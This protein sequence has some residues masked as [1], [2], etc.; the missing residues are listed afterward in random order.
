M[1]RFERVLIIQ[2]SIP[3]DV[4]SSEMHGYSSS[5]Y[6]ASARTVSSYA[7][8]I[9]AT[10]ESV[11]SPSG[12]WHPTF[13]RLRIFREDYDIWDHIIYIDSD[14]VVAVGAPIFP[15]STIDGPRAC[16]TALPHIS[17]MYRFLS[18]LPEGANFHLLSQEL[19]LMKAAEAQY[20]SS[21]WIERSYFNA[22]VFG[23][24]RSGRRRI[25]EALDVVDLSIDYPMYDQTV[26]NLAVEK[27]LVTFVPL[28]CCFN[29]M[30]NL[31][32]GSVNRVDI[33]TS[34]SF[35]HFAGSSKH[36]F[37]AYCRLGAR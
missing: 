7:R 24:N 11:S 34:G 30:V 22:G 18:D 10:Y 5:L 8:R 19:D 28:M 17:Q 35:L 16:F 6:R 31:L 4:D 1:S 33:L 13:E 2:V 32:G 27:S 3:S 36:D 29:V 21:S 15:T 26:L 23:V 20:V 12:D 25:R 37:D 14:V 9:G